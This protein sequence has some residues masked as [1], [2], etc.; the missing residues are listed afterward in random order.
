MSYRKTVFEK[1]GFFRTDIGRKGKVLMAGEEAE[2]SLKALDSIKSSK[3]IYDPS[4]IVFHRVTPT[5]LTLSYQ[6]K[7]I[8]S[9]DYLLNLKV[10]YVKKVQMV[11]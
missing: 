2:F 10:Y 7:R 4:A 6:I 3:I 1:I 8:N 9:E 11:N 5:R